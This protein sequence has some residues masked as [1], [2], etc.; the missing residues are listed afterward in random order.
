MHSPVLIQEGACVCPRLIFW[1]SLSRT[2]AYTHMHAHLYS[3]PQN[4]EFSSTAMSEE[5]KAKLEALAG[6]T[7]NRRVGD[8]SLAVS[9]LGAL[10]P[11][12]KKDPLADMTTT[13]V[14][15][16]AGACWSCLALRVIADILLSVRACPNRSRQHDTCLVT[17]YMHTATSRSGRKGKGFIV[18]DPY[19][20]CRHFLRRHVGCGCMQARVPHGC[21]HRCRQLLSCRRCVI[22]NRD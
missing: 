8:S 15:V 3:L 14:G 9:A 16:A 6:S 18:H 11:S 7:G 17:V 19:P 5:I 2:Y 20:G 21:W 22:H 12:A 4:Q 10:P 1:P 13:V